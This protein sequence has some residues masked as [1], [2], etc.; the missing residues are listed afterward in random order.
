MLAGVQDKIVGL[1]KATTRCMCSWIGHHG[2]KPELPHRISINF[3]S[4]ELK[5]EA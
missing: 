2:Q 5:H 3:R 4:Q 1:L